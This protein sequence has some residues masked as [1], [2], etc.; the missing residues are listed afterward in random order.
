MGYHPEVIL[1]GRRINDNM[2]QFIAQ[3]TIK[4][5]IDAG[6]N[7]KGSKVGVLGLTFK[8]NCPDLRN[9]RVIDIINELKTYNV[10][11]FVHD[12][13]ADKKE[14]KEYYS[15]NLSSWDEIDD[16][17]AMIIAVGHSFY[18]NITIEQYADK[19]IHRGCLIDVKSIINSE[20][21]KKMGLHYWRL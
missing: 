5:M 9:T 3:K 6:H 17:D 4:K 11:V 14:A 13:I 16:L 20:Y 12:P 10:D 15:I 2:G 19:L 21:E 7:I 1:A 18:Q 8:E